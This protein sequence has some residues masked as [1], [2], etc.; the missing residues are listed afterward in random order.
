ME[1]ITP[2]MMT[3]V[4][5]ALTTSDTATLNRYGRL[6]SPIGDRLLAT[7]GTPA[8]KTRIST[9]LNARLAAFVARAGGC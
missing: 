1:V 7:A 5:R 9:M 8:A 2:S 6:I 3:A 4:D